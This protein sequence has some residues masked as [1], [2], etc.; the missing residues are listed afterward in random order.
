ML[1]INCAACAAPLAHDAPRCVRCRTR[2]CNS[3]CQHDHW[4]RGHKQMCKKIHRGGNAEQYYANK[5]YKEALAVAVE[6]CAEDAKGQTCYICLEAVHPSTGEG[7]V[8]GCACEGNQGWVHVSCLVRHDEILFEET[9]DRASAVSDNKDIST[10]ADFSNDVTNIAKRML[11]CRLCK[12]QHDGIIL[13]ALGWAC[14]KNCASKSEQRLSLG[15]DEFTQVMATLA[16]LAMMLGM[17]G[18][19]AEAREV[20]Q[21][22]RSSLARYGGGDMLGRIPPAFPS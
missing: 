22:L 20:E 11:S 18:R 8:R 7:L 12:K 17:S 15:S 5:K 3:T 16:N 19:P 14:W 1:L 13:R 21:T 10:D 4:R 6:A 2:Y 9:K